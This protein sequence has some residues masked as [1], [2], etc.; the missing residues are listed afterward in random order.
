LAEDKAATIEGILNKYNKINRDVFGKL[1]NKIIWN[2]A[3]KTMLENNQMLIK[4]LFIYIYNTAVLK[5]N[6]LQDFYQRYKLIKNVEDDNIE[7]ELNMLIN[8]A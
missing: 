6:H 8:N 3:K 5:E 7:E 4:Y 2:S 1:W